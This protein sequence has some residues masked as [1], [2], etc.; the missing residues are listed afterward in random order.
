M[1]GGV[2]YIFGILGYNKLLFVL[3]IYPPIIPVSKSY[4]NVLV[5]YSNFITIETLVLSFHEIS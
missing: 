4:S 3:L 5:S 1:I 2:S